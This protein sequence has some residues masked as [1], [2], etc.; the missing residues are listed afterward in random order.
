MYALNI[1]SS[2]KDNL[3]DLKYFSFFY[4]FD[5]NKALLNQTIDDMSVYIFIGTIIICVLSS[6]I[7][8]NRKDVIVS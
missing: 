1:I 2:L 3:S 6:A 8:F 4:Y 5:I 7:I